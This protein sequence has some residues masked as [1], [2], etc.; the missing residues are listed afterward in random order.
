MNE[1][2]RL[3]ILKRKYIGKSKLSQYKLI[4]EKLNPYY[5]SLEESDSIIRRLAS[6]TYPYK[7]NELIKERNIQGFDSSDIL[8]KIYSRLPSASQCYAYTDDYLYC[9]MYLT[10]TKIAIKECLQIAKKDDGNT[11]FLLDSDFSFYILVNYYDNTHNDYPNS[12]DI[13]V[14]FY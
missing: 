10:N 6:I 7:E 12:Y 11:C 14:S 8:E 2:P 13:Q 9:G 1:N 4:F 5:I 3:D